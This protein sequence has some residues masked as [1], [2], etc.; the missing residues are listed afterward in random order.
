MVTRSPIYKAM[1]WPMGNLAAAFAKDD[2]EAKPPKPTATPSLDLTGHLTAF[3]GASRSFLLAY[4]CIYGLY[5]G[6]D[7]PAFGRAAT[8]QWSW[9]WPIVLRN[10][11]ATWIICGFWDGFLY[12]GFGI[13]SLKDKLHKYKINPQYPSTQQLVHDAGMTTCASLTAA[14]V[15]I[16]CCHLWCIGVFPRFNVQLMANPLWNLTWAL[17]IT[18]WRVP[19]FWLIHRGMH[20]WKTNS[21]PDVGRFL[22]K[23]V[24]SL[25]HKS[26]NP[27]A[28][29]GTSMHPVE[30]TL[31]Y[32][33]CLIAVPFGCHP[34]IV[35][36][37]IVDCGVGAWLGHD[38]FQ[39]PGSC[40]YFHFI[41]HACFDC[42]YGAMHVPIDRWL[43]TYIE[44][45][46][47]LKK[48]WGDKKVGMEGNE[49]AVH[50]AGSNGSADNKE[51]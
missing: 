5:N 18:H 26:Y 4:A 32:S 11:L 48:V 34:T 7:Y 9:M 8:L 12:Y 36:A 10:L 27:T 40:D 38:G 23:H 30:S 44:D 20:P 6:L 2:A 31:Y 3:C 22:Y 37:C 49:T 41:H 45:K 24:H 19:H 50:R 39:W 29:S 13:K 1:S 33:A 51:Q 16:L 17:T 35:L 43:G 15:E 46:A 14:A 42:N 25:H 21:I 28:F 47:G